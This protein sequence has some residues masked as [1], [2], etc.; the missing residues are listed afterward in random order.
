MEPSAS[1]P[2]FEPSRDG[3]LLVSAGL[4]VAG[5]AQQFSVPWAMIATGIMGVI[6]VLFVAFF[7][8]DARE[9]EE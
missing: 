4:M 1:K 3:V 5:I 8:D 2:K 7:G 6:W 9:A